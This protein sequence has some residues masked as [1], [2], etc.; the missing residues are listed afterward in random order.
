[1]GAGP[2]ETGLS[3]LKSGKMAGLEKL[4]SIAHQLLSLDKALAWGL[5]CPQRSAFLYCAGKTGPGPAPAFL[6]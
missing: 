3:T 2:A 1:M 6:V 4:L 5:P